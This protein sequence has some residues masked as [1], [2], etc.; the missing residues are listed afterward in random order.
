MQCE[1]QLE[2]HHPSVIGHCV[3][4]FPALQRIQHGGT[5]LTVALAAAL[6]AWLNA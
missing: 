1:G 2:R 4:P 5:D 3:Q 6:R